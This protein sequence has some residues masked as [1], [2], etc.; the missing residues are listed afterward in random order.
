[1]KDDEA[2][3]AA[4]C[5]DLADCGW[6][7]FRGS[8]GSCCVYH[9]DAVC[10]DDGQ[11][12]SY[13]LYKNRLRAEYFFVGPGACRDRNGLPPPS[14]HQ[15]GGSSPEDCRAACSADPLCSGY[16]FEAGAARCA[17]YVTQAACPSG[18]P[19][20]NDGGDAAEGPRAVV[21]QPN[22]ICYRRQ[23][24]RAPVSRLTGVWRLDYSNGYRTQYT[25]TK[26]RVVHNADAQDRLA[27]QLVRAY[28]SECPGQDRR[29][30]RLEGAY[31]DGQYEFVDL[32]NGV[33]ALTHHFQDG[34]LC[35]TATGAESGATCDDCVRNSDESGVDCGGSCPPCGWYR[36]LDSTAE[37]LYQVAI[38]TPGA[39]AC[40][41]AGECQFKTLAAAQAFCS[42][43]AQCNGVIG[44]KMT[45]DV[46]CAGGHGCYTAKQAIIVT[47]DTAWY[48]GHGTFEPATWGHWR[49]NSGQQ[50][51]LAAL[52]GVWDVAY[53]NRHNDRRT[54]SLDGAVS[55]ADGAA[56]LRPAATA[57][58]PGHDDECWR[59]E[60]YYG[61]GAW[62]LVDFVN[63]QLWINHFLST[64]A[65]C[66]RGYGTLYRTPDLTGCQLLQLHQKALACTTWGDPHVVTFAGRNSHP[67]GQGEFVLTA[68]V[69]RFR[70]HACHQP[71]PW[72]PAI[73]VNTAFAIT[74]EHRGA[75]GTVKVL[76]GAVQ[77]L[78]SDVTQTGNKLVFPGGEQVVVPH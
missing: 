56:T 19:L 43:Q 14:C 69:G 16:E 39:V 76:S 2:A 44:P 50:A 54:I 42:A 5:D 25:V 29:C 71:V 73:S 59:L 49:K 34:S 46:A 70:V 7:A 62:E 72:A 67:M 27:G 60:G 65:F 6:M 12:K 53:T 9:A 28:S 66:C 17:Y 38:F 21:E 35:C 61:S 64:G 55:G 52:G 10:T 47:P 41:G 4:H 37:K 48:K 77:A 74:W 75:R 78:P 32:V 18:W 23:S 26:D 40:A 45:P 36:L 63:G 51:P 58:C 33:L 8:D 31:P 13:T 11:Y 1:M 15:D 68:V 22:R 24:F 20:V 57:D 3:C 30:W